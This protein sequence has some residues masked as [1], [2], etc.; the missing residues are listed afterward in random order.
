MSEFYDIRNDRELFIDDFLTESR[1]GLDFE[2][3]H[4]AEQ[5]SDPG[6]PNGNYL[7]LMKHPGGY[8]MYY[9]AISPAYTGVIKN[10]NPGEYTAVSDSPDGLHWH[11][12]DLGL[13]PGEPVPPGTIFYRKIYNHNFVPFYDDRPGVPTEERY[14]AV[15]GIMETG[16]LITFVSSD[17]IRWNRLSEGVIIPYETEL[18][19][20][21]S[22]DSQNI[23]FYSEVEKCFVIYF[24]VWKTSDGRIR[25]RT[26]AKIT[27]PDFR[28]WG[29]IEFLNPN[30]PDEHL[31]VSGFFP[32]WRAPQLYVGASTRF[33]AKHGA[34]TDITLLFSRRGRGVLRPFPGAWITPGLDEERWGDRMNYIAYHMFP[35]SPE[36]LGFYLGLKP[37]LYTLRTDGFI[38]LSAGLKTGTWCSKVLKYTSG[39]LEFNLATSAGGA[40]RVGL[41]SPDGTAL[42][43]YALE[44][45]DEFYGDRIA[46]A[47]TW[48]GKGPELVSGTLLRLKIE[49]K[50]CDLYSFNFND[51]GDR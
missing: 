23:V 10:G 33:F 3:R 46:F 34:A 44:D 43:G 30:M 24:R 25:L 40:F 45:C 16:G 7:T 11:E 8:R 47:P 2:L 6:K 37:I 5:P 41:Y 21:H 27:S 38:S 1:E 20:G 48:G 15:A 28:H 50:E 36:K 12:P 32:Y 4:P 9:R 19:G 18:F 13:Y 17:G 26:F 42:P 29:E 49:M 35:I 51:G 14:K 31:Y 39:R 22:L